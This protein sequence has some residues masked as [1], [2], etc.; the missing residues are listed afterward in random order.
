VKG[1]M[2]ATFCLLALATSASAELAADPGVQSGFRA[3][4]QQRLL[5]QHQQGQLELQR[6]QVGYERALQEE[7]TA[8]MRGPS[9]NQNLNSAVSVCAPRA[10]VRAYT[11][12]LP[13]GSGWVQWYGA[14]DSSAQVFKDCLANQG[15]MG[16]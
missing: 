16:R 13:D 12:D 14:T 9:S 5:Q 1:L 11:W 10:N 2:L 4:D 7:R 15:V 8:Q 3:A 6:R